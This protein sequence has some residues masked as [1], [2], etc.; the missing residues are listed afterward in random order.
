MRTRSVILVLALLFLSSPA[1][2]SAGDGGGGLTDRMMLLMVQVAL[3]LFAA[4]FGH[5]LV[6]RAGLPGVLGEVAAGVLIGPHV[7]GGVPL[8]GFARG[9]FPLGVDFPVSPELYGLCSLAAIVLL[10]TVGLET[11]VRLLRRYTLA[12]TLVGLGGV[13]FTFLFGDLVAVAFS[14]MLF[15]APLGFFSPP[16][17]F[18]GVISTATS[19]GISARILSEQRKLDSPEGV[20]ILAG[21]VIDDVLGI[22]LLAVVLGIVGASAS[23]AGIDWGHVGAVAA[24]AVILWLGATAVGLVAARRI[25]SLLKQLRD[26]YAISLLAFGLALLL[27][28]LFEQAGLAMIVGAYVMGL[29]LSQTDICHLVQEKLHPLYAFL[30]PLFFCVMGMLIDFSAL[31]SPEAVLFALVY[32]LVAVVTKVLGCA[33]PAMLCNFNALGGLRIGVGMLP[34]CEIALTIAGIGLARGLVTHEVVGVSV[35]LMVI[36]TLVAPPLLVALLERPGAGTRTPAPRDEGTTLSFPFPN[37]EVADLLTRDAIQAFEAEGFFVHQLDRREALY[38][39]R[40]DEMIIGLRQHEGELQ[41]DCRGPEVPLVHAA[42]LEVIAALERTIAALR[43]PIDSK[44]IAR[45]LQD[46][47]SVPGRALGLSPYLRVGTLAPRLQ[48]RTKDEVIDE[49]LDLLVRLQLVQDREV[50]RRA[51][52]EREAAMSTGMQHGIAIPHAR[53]AAVAGLVCAFGISKEGVDFDCLDGDPAHIFVLT[54][55]PQEGA[56]PH[57]QFM[58]TVSQMLTE[59]VRRQLCR[60]HTA[61]QMLRVLS[62]ETL[63]DLLDTAPPPAAAGTG[64]NRL[65]AWVRPERVVVPLVAAT[66]EVAVDRLLECLVETGGVMDAATARTAVQERENA[67]PTGLDH[68]I[69]IPHARTEAVADLVCAVG[70]APHGI[71]FA[72]PDG[73]L[74]RILILVLS[75]P[76]AGSAHIELLAALSRVLDDEGRRRVLAAPTPGAVCRI[77]TGG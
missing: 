74:S 41:F 65:A 25:S 14:K 9:L 51:I 12:G 53:T 75:P 47:S 29:S 19:V 59:P 62:G 73:Q 54:L 43:E 4:R 68:G 36:T 35:L 63:P 42:M 37:R 8:P 1:F 50:A 18:L 6:A 45:K 69:A 24:K 58:S 3:I 44:A 33:G 34:R 61:A 67:V 46:A 71:D 32:A 66:R 10:F 7:L 49:L 40:K 15:G 76:E 31:A 56:A 13:V 60:C 22:I 11:D 5:Q 52:A 39:L 48:G 20:T 72:A 26:P 70:V 17:L 2:A 27:A 23:P 38:Q 28:G 77:L 57:M 16:C 64:Q 21:A 30:V 55:S